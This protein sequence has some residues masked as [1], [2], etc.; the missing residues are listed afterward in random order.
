MM[1]LL[2]YTTILLIVLPFGSGDPG[3]M[4]QRTI[5][6]IARP[7][8]EK[9]IFLILLFNIIKVLRKRLLQKSQCNQR[10]PESNQSCYQCAIDH[11]QRC[12]QRPEDPRQWYH[13][14]TNEI[15]NGSSYRSP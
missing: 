9:I 7:I 5:N 12:D 3:L 14:T 2:L 11:A 13:G 8:R 10:Y 15:R 6:T 1:F 4:N